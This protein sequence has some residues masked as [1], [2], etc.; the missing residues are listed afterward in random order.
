MVR[1]GAAIAFDDTSILVADDL[2]DERSSKATSRF[3][4]RGDERIEHFSEIELVGNAGPVIA[5][6]NLD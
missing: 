4:L 1:R 5:H 3:F 2:G 6:G